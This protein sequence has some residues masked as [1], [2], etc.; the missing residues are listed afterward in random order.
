[1]L[2]AVQ[3]APHETAVQKLREA[4]QDSLTRLGAP[5]A[6]PTTSQVVARVVENEDGRVRDLGAFAFVALPRANDLVSLTHG[7]RDEVFVVTTVSHL[8]KPLDGAGSNPGVIEPTARVE[9]RF[10]HVAGRGWR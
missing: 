3:A 9:V 2:K 6:S 8:P 1:M 7:R 4:L 5:G 10:Q